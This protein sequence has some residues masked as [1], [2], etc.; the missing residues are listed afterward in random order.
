M[1]KVIKLKTLVIWVTSIF[2][3]IALIAI[4]TPIIVLKTKSTPV[5]M[6]IKNYCG[7]IVLDAGHGGAD[8]GV[9]GVATSV[10]ESDLNFM[11]TTSLSQILVAANYKV[12]T[13]R[14]TKEA[15][16]G[17]SFNK[18]ADMNARKQI[19]QK[20]SPE[21]VISIHM[22]RYPIATRRGIQVFFTTEISRAFA[23][24]VQNHL[25]TT[26]NMPTLNKTFQPLMGDYFI[27]KC[28]PVP[29]IIIECGFLS[30]AKDEALL[31]NAEYRTRLAGEIAFAVQN[32]TQLGN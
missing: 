21:Y 3:I 26:M 27:N 6:D 13:T 24:F 5:I 28:A 19:I 31:S 8:G 15:V 7:Y 25:N 32:F 10:K 16:I 2:L 14:K 1:F 12:V 22:N 9:T 18:N 4:T 17:G 29:S 20:S 23:V 11:L 30:N